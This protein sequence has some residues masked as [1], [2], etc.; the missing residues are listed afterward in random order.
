MTLNDYIKKMT[1]E[2]L[3]KFLVREGI[4]RDFDYAFD[5]ESEYPIDNYI[6]VYYTT[7][8]DYFYS[9][10][11]AIERQIELLQSEYKS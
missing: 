5:G 1:I 2:D 8:G 9:E 10:E 4:Y 11:N 6:D 7:D 3:A